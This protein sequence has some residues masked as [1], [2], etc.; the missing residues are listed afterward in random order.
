[1]A[2]RPGEVFISFFVACY[3]EQENIYATLQT[4]AAALSDNR[5]SY[6]IIVVDDASK[7]H[8]SEEVARFQADRSDI[9]V[10]LIRRKCN[11]GLALN[12]VEAAFAARG[13][14]YRLVCGDNV[15]NVETLHAALA[16]VGTADMVITY[17]SRRVGFS[18]ARN[19]I[20]NLYT[21]TVNTI[22]GHEIKYYNSPTIH[23]R[24]NVLRWHSRS[25]GFSFQA[26]LIAQLLDRGATYVEIPVVATERVNGQSTALSLRNFLSVGHSLLEMGARRLRRRLFGDDTVVAATR[27][28]ADSSSAVLFWSKLAVSAGLLVA[29]SMLNNL[30]GTIETMGRIAPVVF[31]AAVL[32]IT[33]HVFLG[34][35]RWWIILKLGE[36]DIDLFKLSRINFVASFLGQALPAGIGTDSV[37]V[38]LLRRE[39]V[40]T[41]RGLAAVVL[42]R[43]FLLAILLAAC[44]LTFLTL[45][46]PANMGANQAT[47][48]VIGAAFLAIAPLPVIGLLTLGWLG[49]SGFV[50][51]RI[52]DAGELVAGPIRRILSRPGQVAGLAALSVA[53]FTN[54]AF[55]AWLLAWGLDTSI[56]F[57]GIWLIMAPAL[58]AASLPVSLGGCGVRELT[59]VSGLAHVGIPPTTALSLSLLFGVCGVL[60]T[61]PGL[62]IWLLGR[63]MK[64][65]SAQSTLREPAAFS[66]VPQ[67]FR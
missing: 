45:A 66:T 49:K 55:C 6:E 52:G 62:P 48:N 31:L 51:I 19:L 4:L 25:R 37:R 27:N 33:F 32:T 15:E 26:E 59:L 67:E 5:F 13:T 30:Y 53:S 63:N 64:V 43:A 7:D 39:G 56:S 46:E 8:S 21:M 34:A 42:D 23:R 22:T 1:V 50:S 60:G 54:L 16:E 58:L 14:W 61:L 36:V 47:L 18:V 3:N 20:S 10:Q 11:L 2:D 24:A 9:P 28:A 29:L 44:G 57:I 35:L 65:R 38:L 17:P 41:T 12:Y 40:I